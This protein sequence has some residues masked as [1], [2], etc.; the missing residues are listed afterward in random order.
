MPGSTAR[1]RTHTTRRRSG[2]R[3][4][5]KRAVSWRA[6]GLLIAVLAGCAAVGW[7]IVARW[8]APDGNTTQTHFDAVVVL[9]S[10][11]DGDGNP[12]PALLARITEGVREYQRGVASRLIFSGGADREPY[13]EAGVM[14]R[15]AEAQGVPEPAIVL[16]P[17]SLDTIQ[18]ACFVTRVMKAHGW[19]SAEVVTSPVHLPRAGI[20]F[21]KE[22]I[23][24]RMHAAPPLER[25]SALSSAASAALEVLKTMRYLLYANWAE[26]CSP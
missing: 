11:A 8:M 19:R 24:W 5:R 15:V 14:E 18:N 26:R 13:V 21:S 16:E 17:N 22:P 20:I 6:R 12:S 1:S 3:T 2:K 7:A 25:E 9:G 4:A 10:R 23:A